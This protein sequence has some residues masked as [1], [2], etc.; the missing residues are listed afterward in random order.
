MINWLKRLFGKKEEG[1]EDEEAAEDGGELVAVLIE[2]LVKSAGDRA[3]DGG[4]GEGPLAQLL[5]REVVLGGHRLYDGLLD[6]SGGGH[7]AQLLHR[8]GGGEGG[9]AVDSDRATSG[10]LGL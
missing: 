10:D 8:R 5:H 3:L 4:L 7:R 9:V 1:S 2:G 6:G